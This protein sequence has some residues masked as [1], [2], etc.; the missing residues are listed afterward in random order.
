MHAHAIDHSSDERTKCVCAWCARTALPSGHWVEQ[1]PFP[2]VHRVSHGICTDCAAEL[3]AEI[4]SLAALSSAPPA[5]V[6]QSS[7]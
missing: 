3:E 4:E 6:A 1:D 5:A 2:H 7:M